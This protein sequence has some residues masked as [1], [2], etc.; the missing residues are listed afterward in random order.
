[1]YKQL[2]IQVKILS[3]FHSGGDLYGQTFWQSFKES[4]HPTDVSEKQQ[5]GGK[6][7]AVGRHCIPTLIFLP[8]SILKLIWFRNAEPVEI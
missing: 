2:F 4:K 8:I 5:Y 7:I 6:K 3:K 1:M